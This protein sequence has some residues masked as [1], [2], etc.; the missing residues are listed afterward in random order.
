VDYRVELWFDG[1]T[2]DDIDGRV[3]SRAASK[4]VEVFTVSP[5]LEAG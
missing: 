1:G 4:T 2:F 5:L 3:S